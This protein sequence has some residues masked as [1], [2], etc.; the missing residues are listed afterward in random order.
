MGD[1]GQFFFWQFGWRVGNKLFN[2]SPKLANHQEAEKKLALVNRMADA[3]QGRRLSEVKYVPG[4]SACAISE[5]ALPWTILGFNS[6]SF[7]PGRTYGG[8]PASDTVR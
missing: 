5:P 8:G 3:S 2:R 1:K 7:Q 4:K 6:T